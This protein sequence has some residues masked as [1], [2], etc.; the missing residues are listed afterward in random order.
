VGALPGFD[1]LGC[2]LGQTPYFGHAPCKGLTWHE[3]RFF[4]P[5][6]CPD[7][8]ECHQFLSGTNGVQCL[9]M[10]SQSGLLLSQIF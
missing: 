10:V 3:I 2:W 4:G 8:R 1:A 6:P 5:K 7:S 9:G